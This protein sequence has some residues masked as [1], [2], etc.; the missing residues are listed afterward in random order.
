MLSFD[1][2]RVERNVMFYSEFIAWKT[3]LAT[4]ENYEQYNK[5]DRTMTL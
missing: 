5:T 2:K 3:E 1:W 4:V